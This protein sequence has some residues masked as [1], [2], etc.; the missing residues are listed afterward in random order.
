[1]NDK[2]VLYLITISL[3]TKM[4]LAVYKINNMINLDKIISLTDKMLP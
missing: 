2:N 3:Q 1:M 4:Q